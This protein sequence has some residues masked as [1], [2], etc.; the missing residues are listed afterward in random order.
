MATRSPR[1][2]PPCPQ[3]TSVSA[4]RSLAMTAQGAEAPVKQSLLR[5]WRMRG[6]KTRRSGYDSRTACSAKCSSLREISRSLSAPRTSLETDNR[7]RSGGIFIDTGV[8]KHLEA[9][10]AHPAP[11][12]ELVGSS[13]AHMAPSVDHVNGAPH[14]RRAR[15]G[16]A[17]QQTGQEVGRVRVVPC[18]KEPEGRRKTGRGRL[19]RGRQAAPHQLSCGQ[20]GA[21]VSQGDVE[22]GKEPG[23]PVPARSLSQSLA[24]RQRQKR[25]LCA[26][27]E[28]A[29]MM[30]FE[31][32]P[33]PRFPTVCRKRCTECSKPRSDERQH[34]HLIKSIVLAGLSCFR[35]R[36]TLSPVRLFPADRAPFACCLFLAYG[37]DD[38]RPCWCEL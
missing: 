31:R 26:G 12:R 7:N 36:T 13:S 6:L 4:F 3:L 22:S 9:S 16:T 14:H 24:R 29:T 25:H 15:W 34:A 28:I 37:T 20:R 10:R 17:W 38:S 35:P 2:K 1:H 21:G 11:D 18:H 33:P 19:E 27:G 30:D 8:R 5:R 32:C 23:Q